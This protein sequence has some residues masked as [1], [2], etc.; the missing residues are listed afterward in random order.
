MGG[1]PISVKPYGGGSPQLLEDGNGD[2]LRLLDDEEND[3]FEKLEDNGDF[4]RPLEEDDFAKLLELPPR[5]EPPP[6]QTP[7][8][9]GNGKVSAYRL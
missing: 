3:G 5:H 4:P 1:F 6:L 7:A 9:W 8:K 2:F